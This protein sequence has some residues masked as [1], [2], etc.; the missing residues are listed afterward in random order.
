[1]S[2]W[3][4]NKFKPFIFSKIEFMIGYLS[5]LF[6]TILVPMTMILI[7]PIPQSNGYYTYMYDRIKFPMSSIVFATPLEPR[8]IGF[9]ASGIIEGNLDGA[10]YP[11][12]NYSL[13]EFQAPEKKDVT[14][15]SSYLPVPDLISESRA[16]SDEVSI[17]QDASEIT[18]SA[19]E[20]IVNPSSLLSSAIDDIRESG[21]E[22]EN[23]EEVH[24]VPRERIN[25]LDSEFS[26]IPLYG[27]NIPPKDY[28]IVSSAEETTTNDIAKVFATVRFPCN[29]KHETPLRVVFLQ[30]WSSIAFPVPEMH[31]IDVST[32][33][34]LCMF[35][36]EYPDKGFGGSYVTP[37]NLDMKPS[38]RTVDATAIAIYNS[39]SSDFKFPM[40]S[41][42][43]I[44]R[45]GS[46]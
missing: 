37:A 19:I 17:A 7:L 41:S 31:L 21:I 18:Q 9:N 45:V 32:E 5:I 11:A 39:G 14:A 22:A 46:L 30:N 36:L 26:T 42:I 15:N 35:R 10:I 34:S 44:S 43:T 4:I 29:D 12:F 13:M 8:P 25:F 28:L 20:K 40:A 38:R 24:P 3:I 1:M 27:M 6:I 23:P 2:Q 16:P 33:A